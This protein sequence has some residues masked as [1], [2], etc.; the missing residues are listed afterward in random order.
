MD[1]LSEKE[2]L[3]ALR[4]WW[5]ENGN[6]IMGGIAV[7]IIVIF[8]WNWRQNSIA[9]IEIA[10][11]SLFED[12]MEAA[13]RNLL[14]N[15]IDPAETLF[16]DYPDSPYASQARLALARMYMDSGRDKDAADTLQPLALSGASDELSLVGKLRLARIYLYQD[17]PEEVIGLVDGESDSAYAARFSELRGDAFFALER[18][19]EAEAAYIN[20]LSD[21]PQAPTV[22]VMLIQL[23]IN[24]LPSLVEVADAALVSDGNSPAGD[25]TDSDAAESESELDESSAGESE[26]ETE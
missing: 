9:E 4:V 25:D 12:V 10:A 7:G 3:D 11:S 8:G 19:S 6:Y 16:A 17:R 22:D 26:P 13:G 18:Y 14:D 20:A 1:D 2:Q 15:A 24:D 21:N 23:K 5:A